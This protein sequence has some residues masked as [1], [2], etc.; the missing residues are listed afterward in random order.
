MPTVLPRPPLEYNA[1]AMP[2]ECARHY[3]PASDE[4]L[5][6]MLKALGLTKLE[7]LFAHLPVEIRAKPPL[8]VPVELSYDALQDHLAAVAG[9]NHMAAA[10]LGDGLPV[11]RSSAHRGRGLKHSQSDH[12]IH[13]LSAGAEPGFVADALDLPVPHGTAYGF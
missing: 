4:D 7:D 1:D 10:F 2:R 6:A 8:P 11:Y 3:I 12:G 5:G 13:A 9:R